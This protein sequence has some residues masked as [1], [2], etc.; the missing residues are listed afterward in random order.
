[1]SCT[2]C[3]NNCDCHCECT[4]TC[5]DPCKETCGC[6]FEVNAAC[7]RYTKADLDCLDLPQGTNLEDIVDAINAKICNISNGSDGASAYEIAVENGFTGTET[8]WLESLI[9]TCGDC[10]PQ[11]VQYSEAP[12]INN[13]V[14][15]YIGDWT[16]VTNVATATPIEYTPFI[17]T[18]SETANYEVILQATIHFNV[19]LVPSAEAFLVDLA[20][21]SSY[22]PNSRSIT[23]VSSSETEFY[24][25]I[26][27]FQSNITLVAGQTLSFRL[28]GTNRG[29]TDV[30]NL[31]YK[32]VKIS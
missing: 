15:F 14:E 7:V 11:T 32:I 6:E 1:M 10:Y 25:N 26:N 24:S 2:N 9:A 3:N 5:H 4:S 27:I 13:D 22:Y 29:N 18:A 20:V 16:D 23:S 21:N 31:K 28:A 8:E 19:N 30:E 12:L 17:F